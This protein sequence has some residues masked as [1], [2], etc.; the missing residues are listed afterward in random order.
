MKK[1]NDDFW[2]SVL[3]AFVAVTIA[4]LTVGERATTWR[5]ARA[6]AALHPSRPAVCRA[7]PI[8]IPLGGAGGTYTAAAW[9]NLDQ[10]GAAAR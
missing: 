1:N 6:T 9:T 7:A 4:G 5:D 2:M 8:I 10:T 3:V